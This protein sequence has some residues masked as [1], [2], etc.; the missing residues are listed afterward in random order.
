MVLIALSN[1]NTM[2][3]DELFAINSVLKLLDDFVIIPSATLSSI[4]G[5]LLCWL[6]TWGFV[7]HYWVI[8]KWIATVTLIVVG[9]AWLG[10][11]TNAITAI[12]QTERLQ[13]LQNP[14]YVWDQ[15]TLM[16]GAIAQT[17]S[18]L[19]IMA[20]SVLKP[21]GRRK[22]KVQNEASTANS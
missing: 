2:N 16:I 1:R 11:W 8:V 3:G 7:K 13:A 5:A 19:A 9:T 21:W 15:K 12:S 17:I 10:P 14:L 18:L 20:I 6:T 4:T 22:L